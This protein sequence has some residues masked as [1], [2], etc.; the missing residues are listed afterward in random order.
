MSGILEQM[1]AKLE[2][3]AEQVVQLQATVAILQAGGASQRP[4]A[5]AQSPFGGFGG[6]GQQTKLSAPESAPSVPETVTPDMIMSLIQPHVENEATKAALQV[7]MQA[8]GIEG[9]QGTQPHQYRELYGRFQTVIARFQ[10]NDN[11]PR[12][13][14]GSGAAVSII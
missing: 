3:T 2:A 14:N 9:I 11:S 1:H 6:I 5:A 7:E 8:M 4:A 12:H 10:Q 13:T